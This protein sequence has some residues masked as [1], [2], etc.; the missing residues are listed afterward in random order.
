MI[1]KNKK[2]YAKILLVEDNIAD[3]RITKEILQDYRIPI[4]LFV[5]RDGAE[6]INFLQK[7]G[8][9]I[10][11]KTPH[12]ILLDLNLPK[13]NG[14]EVL[15]EIKQD[16]ELRRI[17]VAILTVSDTE[18]DLIKAYSLHANCYIIKPLEM[19][20]F[21]RIVESIINFWFIT[22]KQPEKQ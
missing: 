19:K 18:E 22:V 9:F 20:E 7:K 15:K 16:E 3:I 10:N 5:V 6:A 1:N 12:L 21:Y 17:P 13:K 14:F 11:A 2:N 4:D 8:K